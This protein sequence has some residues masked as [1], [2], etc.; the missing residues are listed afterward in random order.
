MQAPVYMDDVMKAKSGAVS[1]IA[2]GRATPARTQF[3]EAALRQCWSRCAVDA[4]RRRSAGFTYIGLLLVVAVMGISLAAAAGVWQ[5]AQKRDKEEELLFAGDQI[6]RAI[7]MYIANSSA[8]PHRLEDLLKDPGFPGVRRYLRKIYRDP[9]TGSAEWALV[10]SAGDTIIGVHSL[11]DAEPFK[12]S[13]FSFAD[14]DF[15]G[16]TKYSEW[17]FLAKAV[18]ASSGATA[19]AATQG[20]Q[21]AVAPAPISPGTIAPADSGATQFDAAPQQPGISGARG[22]R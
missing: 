8:Y 3:D 12:K 22:H 18:Q 20:S 2:P 16:K 9:M 14:Q 4:R 13:G 21:G 7:G 1:R 5:T 19:P 11:S 17:V 6:R 15:E 10:K